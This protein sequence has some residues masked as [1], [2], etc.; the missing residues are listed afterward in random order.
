MLITQRL[1]WITERSEESTSMLS[2]TH[3][4]TAPLTPDQQRLMDL[5][6]TL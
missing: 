3:D 6:N 2:T 5:R 4:I 1:C